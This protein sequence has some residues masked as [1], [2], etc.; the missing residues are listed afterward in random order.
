MIRL[1]NPSTILQEIIYQSLKQIAKARGINIDISTIILEHPKNLSHGDYSSNI[2]FELAKDIHKNPIAMAEEIRDTILGYKDIKILGEKFIDRIEVVKPGFI[3]FFLSK[4]W[5]IK[6]VREMMKEN[7]RYGHNQLLLGKKVMVEYTD[8][9]PFK[10]F[11][12]GHLYSNTVGEALSRLLEHQG[13][14][15]KRADY[16]GDVGMHVAKAV[17]GIKSKI[18]EQRLKIKEME[19]QPLSERVKFLGQAYAKGATAYEE[20]EKAKVEIKDI[21]YLVYISAQDFLK[22]KYHFKPQVNYRQYVKY[23]EEQ[24]EEV[25]L[26]YRKGREWSLVYF[27]EIYRRLGTKFDFYYPESMVGEYGVQVIKDNPQVFEKSKGAIIFK[28]ERY[29]LHTRVFVNSL[30]LPTYE[31]KELGLSIRKYADYHYDKSLIITGNEINEYF[32]VILK[33]IEKINPEIA[34]KT[35]HIGHGMV[36]LP[37]GKMSSRTG[38]IKTGQWLIEEGKKRAAELIKGDSN[39]T[40]KEKDE[41]IEV[42]GIGAVKY[43]LLKQGIGRDIEFDFD[44][45]VSLEG[46]SGPYL[47]YTYARTRSVLAKLKSA[48][49][50]T[51]LKVQKDNFSFKSLQLENIEIEIL[52]TIYKF[53]EIVQ[54]AGSSYAPNLICNFLFDLAKMYNSFY[55]D[56]PIIRA[57][58]DSRDFRLLLTMATSQIIKNGLYLLGIKVPERM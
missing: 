42:V 30:G 13:A 14:T 52:R 34:R 28:G 53:P 43:A 32:K 31:T 11:H 22:E 25:S 40:K 54:E 51:K 27:E 19:K 2:A 37:E 26:I 5:L 49:W 17:W 39:F 47:Q 10:E 20:D 8:P 58:G 41:L 16:F 29:G 24:L 35:I 18:K 21:N 46:N 7:D 38:K 3:N 55:N 44:T 48:S 12:I 56:Y 50:R 33:V 57:E 9:N 6:E 1:D 45:S 23:S 4:N 36:R 15:V